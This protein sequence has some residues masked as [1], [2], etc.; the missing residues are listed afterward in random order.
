VEKIEKSL[1]KEFATINSGMMH[2]IGAS[3]ETMSRIMNTRVP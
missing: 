3:K 1:I 2:G